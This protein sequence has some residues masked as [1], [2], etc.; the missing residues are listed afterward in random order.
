MSRI[1][2]G[3]VKEKPKRVSTISRRPSSL[4]MAAAALAGAHESVITQ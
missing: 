2:F 3:Q 4:N 1:G